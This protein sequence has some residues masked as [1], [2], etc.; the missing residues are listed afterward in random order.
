DINYWVF[1]NDGTPLTDCV[2]C[3][4]SSQC[5]VTPTTPVCNNDPAVCTGTTGD[6]C[7]CVQC[8]PTQQGACVG[9]ATPVCSPD[10]NTCV[11]CNTHA[12]CGGNKPIC[13]NHICVPCQNSVGGGEPAC[14]DPNAPVCQGPTDPLPGSC[15]ECSAGDQTHC[16]GTTPV[17]IPGVG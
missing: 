1:A 15:T 3:T 11:E 14:K 9:T 2:T 6:P 5:V 8:T 13:Q 16:T 7:Y 10:T 12:Q 4:N 17:C